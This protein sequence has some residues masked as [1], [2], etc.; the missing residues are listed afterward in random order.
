MK[1]LPFERR[2]YPSTC[3]VCAGV[4]L[5]AEVMLRKVEFQ[6]AACGPFEITS[7]ARTAMKGLSQEHRRLWLSQA[8]LPNSTVPLIACANEMLSQVTGSPG[9]PER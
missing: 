5:E 8:R 1:L 2:Y 6:C 4:A 7:A 9:D 3:P